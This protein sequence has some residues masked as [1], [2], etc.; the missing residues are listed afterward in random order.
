MKHSLTIFLAL[1]SLL[2]PILPWARGVELLGAGATFPYPLYS[3]MFYTYWRET[4]VKVNYQAIGSGGGIRQLANMTVDFGGSDAFMTDEELARAPAKI[5]HIPICLGAVVLTYNLPR[6]PN[7]RFTPDLIG[8]IF[9]GK[10]TKW[11]DKRI[12]AI[13]PEVKLPDIPMAVVHRSDGSGTTYVFTDYIGKVSS[14]WEK[15]VG[16][17]KAVNW[18]VGLGAKGNP[19]VAGLIRQLPGALGYVEL[20]Y[21]LQNRMPVTPIKNK[22]GKSVQPDIASLSLAANVPLPEDTRISLTNTD[23]PEGYPI[24]SFTWV[25]VYQ[26]QSYRKRSPEKGRELVRLLWWMT[27]EGQKYTEPLHYAPLSAEAAKKAEKIVKSITCNGNPVH[28]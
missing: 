8:D 22:R 23:A 17:G 26:E 21:A 16:R 3:K 19:G 13:N 5:L 24:I 20:V 14:E 9:L 15:K 11:N 1:I 28:K 25:L 2:V 7:V 27:H 18:P 4:G 6:N 10:I 12:A